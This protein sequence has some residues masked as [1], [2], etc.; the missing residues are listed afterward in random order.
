NVPQQTTFWSVAFAAYGLLVIAAAALFASRASSRGLPSPDE[1]DQA[2][3]SKWNALL[4]ISFSACGSMLLLSLTSQMC[5][6]VAVV[7]FLWVLP[8]SLYLL[9]FVIAF[10]HERWYLRSLAIPL[11]V[12]AVGM[13]IWL[14]NRQYAATEWPISWQITIY[15][16]TIF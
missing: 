5:Q 13:T 2:D 8:L 10:D 3:I 6:D 7:P 9:T 12:A 1:A 15:C 14:M 11:A 16:S 4:W